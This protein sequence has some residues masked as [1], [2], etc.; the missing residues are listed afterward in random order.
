MI[1]TFNSSGS[2][3]Y[4]PEP[5]K[6]GIVSVISLD[7]TTIY[8]ENGYKLTSVHDND[9]CESH[10][11]YV[12]DLRLVDFEGLDFDLTN[13]NFFN[14]IEGYGIELIPIRGHSVKIAGHGDNNGYYSDQLDLVIEKDDVEVKRYDIT[15]CQDIQ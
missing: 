1:T 13:D 10:E 6:E 8:F 15:K 12:K 7:Y 9:C 5:K 14:R 4:Q 3:Y 11:L 2:V